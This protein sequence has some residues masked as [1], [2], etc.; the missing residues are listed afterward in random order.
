MRE[1]KHHHRFN[2]DAGGGDFT[3][4]T[5]APDDFELHGIDDDRAEIDAGTDNRPARPQSPMPTPIVFSPERAAHYLGLH[6]LG[7]KDPA[8]TMLRYVKRKKIGHVKIGGHI[9]FLKE[10]LED[11]VN[12]QAEG[13]YTGGRGR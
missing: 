4:T 6:D 11:F 9:G 3:A 7:V 1:F 8:G 2:G 10:H 13:V 12:M 5:A